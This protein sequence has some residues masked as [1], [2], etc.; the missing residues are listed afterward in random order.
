MKSVSRVLVCLG[1]ISALLSNALPC[2]PGY[3]TPLFDTTSSPEAPYTDFAAGRLG[4]VKPRFRRSVLLVA[5]RWIAGNGLTASEQRDI[6]DVWRAEI[7]NRDQPDDTIDEAVKAWVA[8]RAEVV[9]KD[10]PTPEIYVERTY[11][12]YDFFPNC[13]KNAF[14]TATETLG[15][16]M[17][18]HGREDKNVANWLAGQDQ[19]FA[20]CASGKRTP[21]DAPPGAP[22]WLV[23]DRAYQKAAA[24]FYSMD[25]DAAKKHFAE[26]AEDIDSP[27]AETAGYL[28]GRTLVRQASLSKDKKKSGDLY[29]EAEEILEKYAARGGKFSPSSERLLGLIK[30]RT[31]PRERVSELAKLLTPSGGNDNFRQD[32]ID[33]TWLL[34]K[35]EAELL[36][37]EEKRKRE[38]K[39]AEERRNLPPC[40]AGMPVNAL[41]RGERPAA[42]SLH[43][44]LPIFGRASCRE[45]V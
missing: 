25:Y 11:G 4:I 35:F 36:A 42:L 20:N 7:D 28:I 6:V 18:M 12:G 3:I 23:K 1:L 16:R 44:A 13:T 43:D 31:R 5:Y 15:D 41:C 2:G 37:A 9:G 22:A 24:E 38:L 26:I 30:Y 29:V 8:L 27:W 17:S 40:V 39:E 19:V 32:V 21:D 45:R 33:Y 34:D 14:E 10:E